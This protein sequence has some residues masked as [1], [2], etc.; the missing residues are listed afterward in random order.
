MDSARYRA[1][2][3][4]ADTSEVVPL[5]LREDEPGLARVV[6]VVVVVDVA[7]VVAIAVAVADAVADALQTPGGRGGVSGAVAVVV[8][9]FVEAVG[10]VRVEVVA[11]IMVDGG[12]RGALGAT[13]SQTSECVAL[14]RASLRTCAAP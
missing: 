1:T 4:T 12:G 7:L 5:A 13:A 8:A 6:I 3:A 2:S 11:A 10:C 14:L 9:V